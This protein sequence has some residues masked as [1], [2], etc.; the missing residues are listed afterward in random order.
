M[1]HSGKIVFLRLSWFVNFSLG[2]YDN[3]ILK[4]IVNIYVTFITILGYCT[5][6][7]YLVVI[8]STFEDTAVLE[9]LMNVN[10]LWQPYKR[11]VDEVRVE[12]H[13]NIHMNLIYDHGNKIWKG[14]WEI[15]LKIE[16][17][18]WIWEMKLRLKKELKNEN[19]LRNSFQH[20][21]QKWIWEMIS[22]NEF[23]GWILMNILKKWKNLTKPDQTKHL[24]AKIQWQF[25]GMAL[26]SK[27]TMLPCSCS[28][29]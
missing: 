27:L 10:A 19:Q 29:N 21:Y 17:E 25:F 6:V 1:Q 11:F 18:G 4:N 15:T 7:Y 16:S 2:F 20:E 22:R 8:F 26:S 14:I 3:R 9:I 12:E 28:Q 23:E 13:K 24:F 5:F